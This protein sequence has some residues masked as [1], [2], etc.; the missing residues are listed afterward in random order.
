MALVADIPAT[1]VASRH[2]DGAIPIG[3]PP[4]RRSS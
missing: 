3:L 2:E 4:D 1:L